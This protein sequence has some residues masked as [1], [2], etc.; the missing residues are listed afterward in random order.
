MWKRNSDGPIA[1]M[2][3]KEWTCS[4]E[5]G[6]ALIS[7]M[8]IQVENTVDY[9]SSACKYIGLIKCLSRGYSNAKNIL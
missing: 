1:Q 6:S 3:V 7:N 2:W 8:G 9:N 5:Y 4:V